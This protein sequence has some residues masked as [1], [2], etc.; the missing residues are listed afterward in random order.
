MLLHPSFPHPSPSILALS[1]RAARVVLAAFRALR[2]LRA[3]GR[4][5]SEHKPTSSQAALSCA[6]LR[7]A[8]LSCASFPDKKFPG[9]K[10]HRLHASSDKFSMCVCV[11]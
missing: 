3:A 9:E 4:A 5:H 10:L 6:Q 8:A 7:S 11:H 2:A 1:K